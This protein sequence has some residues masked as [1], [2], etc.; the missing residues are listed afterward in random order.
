M[1]VTVLHNQT[2]L[3]IAIQYT[4]IVKNSFD[5]AVYNGIS[6][7]DTLVYG[8]SLIIPDDLEIDIDTV[9]YYLANNLQP[10]TEIDPDL[11]TIT[12]LS[13]IGYWE[14]ENEFIITE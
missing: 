11:I 5:I 12:P 4:G 3:D 13:G 10:S 7:S 9:N 14:I 8:A 2:L 6:V 1:T